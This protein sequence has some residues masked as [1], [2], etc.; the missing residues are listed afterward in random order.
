MKFKIFNIFFFLFFLSVS[1]QELSPPASRVVVDSVMETYNS[2][3]ATDS[4]LKNNPTTDNSVYPKTFDQKFQ[5]KYKGADFDYTNI[6]PQESLWQRIQKRIRKI[7]ESIFG[8]MDPLKAETY[9]TNIVRGI[10]VIIIGFVLYFLIKFL[11]GRDGNFFFSKK[12]KRINISDQDLQENIHEINFDEII[13]KSENLKDFRPAVR[14]QFLFVLKKLADQKIINWNPEKT[15]K[16][17]ISE[18]MSTDSKNDFKEVVYIFENV[19]YGEFEID[20]QRYNYFKQK[21]LNFKM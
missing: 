17:Y 16:D 7:L 1:S 19:W 10:A 2:Q 21:F 8:K 18:L 13:R 15:N 20:E 4:L 9:I 6:K 11:L 12:N 14:Y 5:T 3:Y